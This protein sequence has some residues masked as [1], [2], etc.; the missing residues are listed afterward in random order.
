MFTLKGP[1]SMKVEIK[2]ARG[3]VGDAYGVRPGLWDMVVPWL[4]AGYTSLKAGEETEVLAAVSDLPAN[5][6]V[7][8]IAARLEVKD[9]DPAQAPPPSGVTIKRDDE[10]PI[11]VEM[12][13]G[14]PTRPRNVTIRL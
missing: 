10:K 12:T 8:S 4:V 7:K 6:D 11:R 3:F 9:D 14:T 5:A 2:G 1:E 13:P